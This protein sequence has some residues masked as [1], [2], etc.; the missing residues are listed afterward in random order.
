MKRKI[1]LSWSAHLDSAHKSP[2]QYLR[3]LK[4]KAFGWEGDTFY[5][6]EKD[7]LSLRKRYLDDPSNDTAAMN[8]QAVAIAGEPMRSRGLGDTVAKITSAVGIK[9]CG[10]CKKRQ[11]RLNNLIPYGAGGKK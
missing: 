9:P 8:R 4:A 5:L 3:D 1:R 6:T 10:G 2:P 7:F 11:E